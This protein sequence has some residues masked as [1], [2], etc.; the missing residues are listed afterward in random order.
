MRK[1]TKKE[2][3]TMKHS[4][5]AVGLFAAL[6]CSGLRAQTMDLRAN[7]PFDFRLGEKVMPA[8]QYVIHHSD[9]VL[10][11]REQN[12][13]NAT[14]IHLTQPTIRRDTPKTGQLVF[15]RY[16]ENYFLSQIWSPY[17][18]DGRSLMKSSRERE[19][20]KNGGP[21]YRAGIPAQ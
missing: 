12:G 13:G 4:F 21:V 9:C 2:S 20:A 17:S 5:L 1:T 6:A 8:G 11:V 16:G 7:V 3:K 18:K 15:N 19:V 10:T 14:V